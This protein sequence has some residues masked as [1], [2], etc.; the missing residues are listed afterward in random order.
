M[1]SD[2]YRTFTL[3]QSAPDGQIEWEL[4]VTSNGRVSA[5]ERFV[6]AAGKAYP[7]INHG[8]VQTVNDPDAYADLCVRAGWEEA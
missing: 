6:N 3:V 5:S 4:V 8:Y 2:T 1:D 7:R